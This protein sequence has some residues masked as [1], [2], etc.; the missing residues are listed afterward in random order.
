MKATIF[1]LILFTVGL[2]FSNAQ[3]IELDRDMIDYGTIKYDSDGARK[4]IIKNTGKKPLIINNVLTS[5][6]CTTP[7][8]PD[9]PIAPGAIEELV[10]SYDTKRKG[11]FSKS[12][13]ILSNAQEKSRMVVSIKGTVQ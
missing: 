7:S 8:I 11:S 9:K 5:C 13:T 4:F 12:I 2:F 10:V 3:E 1:S 6:G